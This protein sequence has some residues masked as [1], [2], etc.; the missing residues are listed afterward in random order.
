MSELKYD[1]LLLSS[2]NNQEEIHT[3]LFTYQSLFLSSIEPDT[4]NARFL[5]AVLIEDADAKLFVSRKLTK[6]QLLN[7][8]H[9]ENHVIIGKSCMINCLK[10]ASEDWK[11]ANQTIKT[12]MDLGDNISVSELIQ[13]PTLYPLEN[14][15]Y[16]V[17]TG[18]RR[19][20]A[21]I[22]A[23]GYGSA[24]QFKVYD[25]KPLLTKV[26]QFQ[27]NAS[28]EDLPQYGK[29][30][31][32]QSALME[33]DTLNNARLKNG[34][35]KLTVKETATNLGISMGA[36]DNYN[37][38]TRYACVISAYESGLSLPFVKVKKVVLETESEYKSKYDK[39]VLN[40]TDKTNISDEIKDRLFNKKPTEK[41]EKTFKVKP[42]KSSS[43]I[44][45]LLTTN[46]MMLDTG[47]D[48][49]NVNWEDHLDVSD[50]ME[51]VITFLENTQL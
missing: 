45:T 48:W 23:N 31:A 43:T 39:S 11:K 29:L 6:K 1:Q 16:R 42:I 12:I 5:P 24:A 28:R 19:F 49:D 30:Q 36:F 38:L 37:V 51:K 20:F 4:T 27:E 44:K 33:I 50:T 22:Y 8:Y 17:L 14:G 46:V 26:K 40:I 9:G 47:I 3:A 2:I 32:F 34:L 41:V 13:A 7:K 18:H 21:L 25:S 10:Y 15:R 35:K